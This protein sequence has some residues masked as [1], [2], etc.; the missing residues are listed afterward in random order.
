[1][2]IIINEVKARAKVH[3]QFPLIAVRPTAN[4]ILVV[5]IRSNH[6][7]EIFNRLVTAF[8][9][10]Y[11]GVVAADKPNNGGYFEFLVPGCETEL[12]AIDLMRATGFKV[13]Q[14][15]PH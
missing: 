13:E 2:N 7:P 1:M 11:Q 8:G 3:L 14:Q 10:A 12:K 4:F 6:M 5:G 15:P 9:Q